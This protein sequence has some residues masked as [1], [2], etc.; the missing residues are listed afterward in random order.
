MPTSASART[1]AS[2]WAALRTLWHQECTKVVP[3]LI[4]SA[5]ESRVLWKMS[6]AFICWP[7]RA[8]VGKLPSSGLSP[9]KLR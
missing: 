6:S 2:A 5:A 7:K 1:S 9:E 4:A 3:E 8:T